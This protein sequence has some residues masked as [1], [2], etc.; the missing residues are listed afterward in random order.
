[1]RQKQLVSHSTCR[2]IVEEFDVS[3]INLLLK[4]NHLK[5]MA[6]VPVLHVLLVLGHR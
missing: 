5:G 1:M 2:P 3:G 4:L 6:A